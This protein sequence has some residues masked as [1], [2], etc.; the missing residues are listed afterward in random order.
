[1]N[2]ERRVRRDSPQT[3]TDRQV[4]TLIDRI[5]QIPD[6]TRLRAEHDV[7]VRLRDKALIALAWIFFKRGNE[8]LKVKR[9][10]V[11]VTDQELLVT[12]RIQKKA[13]AY[14]VCPEC[15]DKN[16]R[17][18]IYCKTCGCDISMTPLT[19]L[20]REDTVVTKRKSLSFP[21]CRYVTDWIGII[22][23]L[24]LKPKIRVQAHIFPPF[25]FA[26][27]SWKKHL[28]VQRFDQILQRL[29]PTLTSH[30][31]RYGATEK[32]LILGYTPY[33]AKEIGDWASS[34]MPEEYAKR[35]GLTISQRQYA[36][37]TRLL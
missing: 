34:R 10:E 36:Q 5:D 29:D 33:E 15:G 11:T 12:F 8:I 19:K 26:G 16:A 18:A 4:Q 30:M 24:E 25:H 31:F 22:D 17:R 27:F 37:D 23:A 21:F 3:L 1:M 2:P 14:R 35:K 7:L 32:L 20:A 13:K 28:T 9:S 6:Y